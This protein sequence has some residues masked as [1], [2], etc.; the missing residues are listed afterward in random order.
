MAF[1]NTKHNCV[2]ASLTNMHIFYS[3]F[4]Q[5]FEVLDY[6]YTYPFT[7]PNK[8]SNSISEDLFLTTV[9]QE[10]FQ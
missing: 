4:T 6:L 9:I 1:Q 8:T 2:L 10:Y 7:I 5:Q 3:V